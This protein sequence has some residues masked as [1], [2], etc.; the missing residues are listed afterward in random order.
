MNYRNSNYSRI[1]TEHNDKPLYLETVSGSNS[2]VGF[3]SSKTKL[4]HNAW[5]LPTQFEAVVLLWAV[6]FKVVPGVRLEFDMPGI[7][8]IQWLIQFSVV[9]EMVVSISN[10]SNAQHSG[11]KVG[12][13]LE[14][15]ITALIFGLLIRS[16]LNVAFSVRF[17][18]RTLKT[19][20]ILID[21]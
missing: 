21:R 20:T 3:K 14:T 13:C 15:P 11:S 7:F 16:S 10:L 17:H 8:S 5:C 2:F 9:C 6:A 1:K 4:G 18:W 12:A 19:I